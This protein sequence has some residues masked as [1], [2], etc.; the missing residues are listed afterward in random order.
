MLSYYRV[1]PATMKMV[2]SN[3]KEGSKA[4]IRLETPIV[5]S[6]VSKTMLLTKGQYED[7]FIDRGWFL[8]SQSELNI[9]DSIGFNDCDSYIIEIADKNRFKYI[10]HHCAAGYFEEIKLTEIQDF[11]GFCERV[12]SQAHRTKIGLLDNYE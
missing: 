7:F 2:S 4:L 12:V 11:I 9:P 5:D 6:F 10:R 3:K 1:Y 8:K